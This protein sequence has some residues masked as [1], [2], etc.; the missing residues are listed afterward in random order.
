MTGHPGTVHVMGIGGAGM[1]GIA[2]IMEAQGIAVS[3]CDERESRRLD[4]LRALGIDCAIGHDAR[5]VAG[6]ADRSGFLVARQQSGSAVCS[7]D[8]DSHFAL[9]SLRAAAVSSALMLWPPYPC[10]Q[11]WQRPWSCRLRHGPA[12]HSRP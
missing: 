11:P 6:A 4:A 1:S 8:I 3:G 7:G 10:P 9:G 2:R 12:G 5:H